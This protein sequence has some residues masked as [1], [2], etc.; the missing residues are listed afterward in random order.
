MSFQS[1][2][3]VRNYKDHPI[4]PPLNQVPNFEANKIVANS[5]VS[6]GD[7]SADNIIASD[8]LTANSLNVPQISTQTI[9]AQ[10]INATSSMSAPNFS[11]NSLTIA[12]P[13]Q[14]MVVS[15]V[16]NAIQF[17]INGI[18]AMQLVPVPIV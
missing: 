14:N 18:T 13:S 4:Q 6:S 15:Q 11:T 3:I 16:G 1:N 9:T 2:S 8:N 12:G 17:N 5:I 7:I 10:T